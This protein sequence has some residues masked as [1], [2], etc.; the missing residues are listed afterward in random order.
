M[1]ISIIMP[2]YNVSEYLPKAIDSV[3]KQTFTDFELLLIDDGSKDDS[4]KICDE[5]AKKDSRISVFHKENGGLSSARNYGIEQAKAELIGFID[6]DD[7]ISENMYERLY[8]SLT[9]NNADMSMCRVLDC[10]SGEIPSFQFSSEE[11]VFSQEEAIKEILIAE[12]ASVWAVNKLYKKTLFDN[13]RYPV[14]KITEDGFVIL[15]LL[16]QCQ[17]V[18]LVN[19]AVYYY[20]H[21]ENSITTTKFSSKN[22]NTIEA[23]E[24]N[25]QIVKE[26]FPNVEYE[27][28][29]RVI[30]AY[31]NVLDKMSHLTDPEDIKKRK[32]FIRY[33]RGNF[34]FIIKCPYFHK[35]RKLS[36]AVLMVSGKLYRKLVALKKK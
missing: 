33:I 17:R 5:Y 2:V 7:L 35:S 34:W 24:R 22:Y 6:S 12:K 19:D 14:G 4:G 23:W 29:M 9:A 1:K 20:M 25:Y 32:E 26:K 3:L 28:K 18:V 15:D 11:E 21:R 13:V 27:A 30:W 10:Y 16:S 36:A 8:D 31:F